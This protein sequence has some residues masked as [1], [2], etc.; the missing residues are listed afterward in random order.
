MLSLGTGFIKKPYNYKSAKN[1]GAVA[2]KTDQYLRINSELIFAKPDMDDA[3]GKNFLALEQEG[4][5]IVAE[6]NV[7]FPKGVLF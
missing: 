5:R 6:F 1:L 4:T 7:P 2:G 3:S